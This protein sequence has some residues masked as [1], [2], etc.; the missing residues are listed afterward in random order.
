MF[1]RNGKQI[2][3]KQLAFIPFA[4]VNRRFIPC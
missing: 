3:A 2:Y 4:Y 1:H